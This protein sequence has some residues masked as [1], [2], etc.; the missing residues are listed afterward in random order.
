MFNCVCAIAKNENNYI[1]EWCNHYIKMGFKHIY[2]Y[3][4]NDSKTEYVGNFIDKE[5]QDQVTIFNWNNKHYKNMQWDAYQDFYNSYGNICD[6][7]LY[8]DIDEF[9]VGIDNIDKFLED[10]KFNDFEQIRVKWKLFGDDNLIERDLSIPVMESF[11]N[12]IN[13]NIELSNQG[14]SIVRGKLN[15]IKIKS[16]HYAIYTDGKK[17]KTCL[18]SGKECIKD[19][20]YQIMEDYTKENV[21]INHYMTRSLSEFL[22][23]KYKRGDAI[24]QSR[25]INLD[26]Y[27][28][29][30]NKTPEKIKYIEEFETKFNTIDLVVPYVD[31]TD[32]EWLSIFNKYKGTVK[33]GEQTTAENRFRSQDNFF[34]YFF[35]CIDANMKFIRKIFLLV[36]MPSQVPTWL[37]TEKITI[38]THDQFIPKEYLPTFN[39]GTIEMFLHRI[40]GLSEKFIYAN[41]DFYCIKKLSENDFFENNKCKFNIKYSNS[42]P[43][44]AGNAWQ[45]LNMCQNNHITIFPEKPVIPYMRLG[46]E[47]RPYFKSLYEKCFN[48]NKSKILKSITQ[49]RSEKNLTCYL[50][51]LFLHKEGIRQ[52]SNLFSEVISSG[53]SKDSDFVNFKL[54]NSDTLCLN[55]TRTDINIYSNSNINDWFMSNFKYPSKYEK[56]YNIEKINLPILRENKNKIIN[57]NNT[58]FHPHVVVKESTAFT[59]LPEEWWKESF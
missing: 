57:K 54:K 25:D 21:F 38:I 20:T 30:N 10:K 6:W 51:S 27:W 14:K 9:L 29:L 18:P 45:W 39:S 1:N 2:L 5:I 13:D 7:I 36:M 4:N 41:D 28:Q 24:K 17:L 34:R 52:N 32:P 43:K 53:T 35:R 55:D 33:S 42:D 50:F 15:N 58:P 47:F 46:H 40:P 16:C 22:N 48:N 44:T 56:E 11:K 59:G 26:Y 49:F 23:T 8:C 3:D 12:P 19:N 31:N 37:N